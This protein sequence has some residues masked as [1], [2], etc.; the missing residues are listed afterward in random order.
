MPR[1]ARA[2]GA[3][4]PFFCLQS[5]GLDGRDAPRTTVE[6]MGVD[7]AAEIAPVARHPFVLLGLAGGAAVALETARRLAA[8]GRSRPPVVWQPPGTP[9]RCWWS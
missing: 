9:R 6:E 2:L 7:F 3:E 8:A 1:L 4:Q 5:R